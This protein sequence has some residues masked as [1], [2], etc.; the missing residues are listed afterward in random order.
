VSSDSL[1]FLFGKNALQK[2]RQGQN[3]IKSKIYILVM[4]LIIVVAIGVT[5]FC[6]EYPKQN[7][8][9]T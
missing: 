2:G 5:G 7:L 6:T 3:I 8:G 4:L 9:I 1:N